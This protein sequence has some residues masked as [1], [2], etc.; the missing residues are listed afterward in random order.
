MDRKLRIQG[1]LARLI[2]Q[3][4]NDKNHMGW[5]VILIHAHLFK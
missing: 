1:H 2:K 3:N 4:Y 5:E